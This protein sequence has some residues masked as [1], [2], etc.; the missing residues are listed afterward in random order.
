MSYMPNAL[1]LACRN[2]SIKFVA[3]YGKKFYTPTKQGIF[4]FALS[5][6]INL[7][8]SVSL[9]FIIKKKKK[10]KVP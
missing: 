8:V 3:L 2:Y 6:Q 10:K 9:N 4:P 5:F 7:G 1:N